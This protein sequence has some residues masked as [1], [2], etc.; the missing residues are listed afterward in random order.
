MS[1][2]ILYTVNPRSLGTLPLWTAAVAEAERLGCNAIHLNPFHPTTAVAKNFHGEQVSGS[3][4]AI[5][6]HF[7]INSEFCGDVDA[8]TAR[9]Q[10]K[11]FLK[12]A[13]SKKIRV[14]ADLVFN[15]VAKDPP[16]VER[17]PE[18]FMRNADG[19]VMVSGPAEDPWS[20]IAKINYAHPSAWDY[21]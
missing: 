6:D 10:L 20:D 13:R 3:L 12:L 5:R 14:L 21:F 19:S 18:F 4:Y 7:A 16:L 1:G 8:A 2:L 15:H 11:D 9:G 17:F